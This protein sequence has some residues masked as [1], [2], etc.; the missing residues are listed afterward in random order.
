MEELG[1]SFLGWIALG[2]A[3]DFRVTDVDRLAWTRTLIEDLDWGIF[4]DL[5]LEGR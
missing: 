4:L 2:E 5:G 3:K 1:V